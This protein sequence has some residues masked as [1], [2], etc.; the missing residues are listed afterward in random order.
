MF[1]IMETITKD[2]LKELI[3]EQRTDFERYVGAI[4]ENF[5]DQLGGVAEM[6]AQNT[7][8]I[9]EIKEDIKD[10]KSDSKQMNIKVSHLEEIML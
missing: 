3:K 9:S 6:V 2:Y 8:D 4:I 7:V 1:Y 5:Q 10:I